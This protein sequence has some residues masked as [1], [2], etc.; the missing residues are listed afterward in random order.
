MHG[1]AM[2]VHAVIGAQ[3]F[4]R[5]SRDILS[6]CK[7]PNAVVS[8]RRYGAQRRGRT[9]AV[10]DA[11]AYFRNHRV[12]RSVLDRASTAFP[13]GIST[14]AN[15]NW[16]CY[17]FVFRNGNITNLTTRVKALCVWTRGISMSGD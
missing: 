15:V 17:I 12:A 5:K 3:K 14:R 9:G 8:K 1:W 11:S 4:M 10:Q 2:V 16:N 13:G 7:V 6:A